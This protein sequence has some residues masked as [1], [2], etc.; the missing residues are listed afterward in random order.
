MSLQQNSDTELRRKLRKLWRGGVRPRATVRKKKADREAKLRRL[1]H[2]LQVH[3]IEL[4]VQ[5]R[6][7]REAQAELEASRN[8]YAELYDFAPVGYV[9]FDQHGVVRSRNADRERIGAGAEPDRREA[10]FAFCQSL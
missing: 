1:V 7:L 8:E 3:Q 6:E 9:D 10:V 4:E 2:D 5:N